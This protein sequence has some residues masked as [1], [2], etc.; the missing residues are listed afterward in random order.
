LHRKQNN[1][2]H[3]PLKSKAPDTSSWA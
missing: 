1:S 2:R 3:S